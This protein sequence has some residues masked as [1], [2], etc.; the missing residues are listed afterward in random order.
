M[1]DRGKHGLPTPSCEVPFWQA[2]RLY[3][4][5][6]QVAQPLAGARGPAFLPP[7]AA[8]PAGPGER[9]P[10]VSAARGAGRH[11]DQEAFTWGGRWK[12]AGRGAHECGNCGHHRPELHSGGLDTGPAEVGPCS[13]CGDPCERYGHGGTPLC[14]GQSCLNPPVAGRRLLGALCRGCGR[15]VR[16]EDGSGYWHPLCRS[17][18]GQSGFSAVRLRAALLAAAARM[19]AQASVC[20]CPFHFDHSLWGT[21]ATTAK[22]DHPCLGGPQT[23]RSKITPGVVRWA[24]GRAGGPAGGGTAAAAGPRRARPPATLALGA[25][26]APTAAPDPPTAALWPP[27]TT[28]ARGR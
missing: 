28:A 15:V 9:G 26:A 22:P 11:C 23:D 27:L 3:D 17:T 5:L 6:A 1:A 13:A 4:A 12:Q 14:G 7:S 18:A 16:S 24:R 8:C 19:V 21:A 2:G 20:M 25:L 10:G